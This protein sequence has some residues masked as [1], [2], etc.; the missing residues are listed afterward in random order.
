MK[1]QARFAQ[2]GG[3]MARSGYIWWFDE[4]GIE[5]VA[6]VGGK[7]A[8]LGELY[9][10]LGATGVRAANGFAITAEA[11]RRFVDANAPDPRI[12]EALAGLDT[13]DAANLAERGRRVRQLLLAGELPRGLREASAVA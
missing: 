13:R 3:G 6:S 7:N 9:R 1:A 8:S 4:I 10:K 5:D 12:R 2:Q 11:Y